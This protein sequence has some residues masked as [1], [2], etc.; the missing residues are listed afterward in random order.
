MNAMPCKLCGSTP[1]VKVREY[2]MCNDYLSEYYVI[3]SFCGN[4]GTSAHSIT[5]AIYNWNS[6]NFKVK[7]CA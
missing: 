7:Y 4:E 2:H 6:E 5:E 3:C 1:V